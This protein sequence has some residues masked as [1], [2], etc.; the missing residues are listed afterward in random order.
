MMLHIFFT[1]GIFFFLLS[2]EVDSRKMKNRIIE[3]QIINTISMR[4]NGLLT[5]WFKVR[6][7]AVHYLFALLNPMH[8]AQIAFGDG[9]LDTSE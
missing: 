2:F 3:C 7:T 5:I 6:N 8:W 9:L 1:W 4:L